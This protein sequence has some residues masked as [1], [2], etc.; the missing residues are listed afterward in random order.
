MFK[1]QFMVQ[2]LRSPR[3][4]EGGSA[5]GL[6]RQPPPCIH[7]TLSIYPLCDDLAFWNFP[8]CAMF[9][10]PTLPPFSRD[11]LLSAQGLPGLPSSPRNLLSPHISPLSS[12]FCA[13]SSPASSWPRPPKEPPCLSQTQVNLP[14]SGSSLAL[15]P[16]GWHRGL[17]LLEM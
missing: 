2:L 5:R 17:L 6:V 4:R 15:A 14:A 8:Q 7:P 3:L 9:L 1:A 16:L 11:Q 12:G 10:P 13:C